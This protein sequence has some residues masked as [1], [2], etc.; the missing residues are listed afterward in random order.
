MCR[1]LG[2]RI[3]LEKGSSDF[4]LAPKP[5]Q[6]NPNSTSHVLLENSSTKIIWKHSILKRA[7]KQPLARSPVTL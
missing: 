5:Y 6:I 4:L 2:L 7:Q 1:G 3:V